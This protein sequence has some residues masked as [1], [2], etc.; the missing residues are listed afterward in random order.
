[1]N[2]P[3]NEL[4]TVLF[5]DVITFCHRCALYS[6]DTLYLAHPVRVAAIKIGQKERRDSKRF[7]Q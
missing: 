2:E 7:L 1:M 4:K 5:L 6:P 3:A